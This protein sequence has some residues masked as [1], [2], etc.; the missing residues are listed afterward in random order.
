MC[1][2]SSDC[3]NNADCVLG[4]CT[5]Y[6]TLADGSQVPPGTSSYVC[7][8]NYLGTFEGTTKCTGFNYLGEA[9]NYTTSGSDKKCMYTVAV[10]NLTE[11]HNPGVC[12][13]DG[14]A[15]QY[16][17]HPGTNSNLWTSLTNQLND[18]FNG[19][20]KNKHSYRRKA[21]SPE[22]QSANVQVTMFPQLLKA[23]KCTLK[24]FGAYA[25]ASFAKISVALLALLFFLF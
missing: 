3:V 1:L 17:Y 16:C 7:K 8:S 10:T 22:L 18:W 15:N 4:V 12:A 20:A 19:G 2:D 14:S 5:A 9:G 6:F 21:W 25:S 23:D 11:D 13:F 24:L